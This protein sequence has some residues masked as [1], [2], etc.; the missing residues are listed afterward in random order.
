MTDYVHEKAKAALDA[1]TTDAL[2][3]EIIAKLQ[4]VMLAGKASPF[5]FSI[6]HNGK[7][8]PCPVRVDAVHADMSCS[9]ALRN[10]V[11]ARTWLAEAL[12]RGHE[13]AC[14]KGRGREWQSIPRERRSI[15]HRRSMVEYRAKRAAAKAQGQPDP[16]D[17][18][19][20]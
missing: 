16:D 8:G 15:E 5:V 9:V 19:P 20:F 6:K 1:L 14:G 17:E 2:D 7:A 4:D 10:P 3:I 12:A 18:I 11:E 13:V